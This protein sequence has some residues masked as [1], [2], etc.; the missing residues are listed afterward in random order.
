MVS[1]S[2]QS[3]TGQSPTQAALDEIARALGTRATRDA[4]LGART[5]YRVG[6]RAALLVEAADEAD[7]RA[8]H[9]ALAAAGGT[10]GGTV[11]VLVIGR[12]SNMLVADAGFPGLVIALGGEF[13][14]VEIDRNA[15]KVRAGGA[16]GLQALA[17]ET[18][19]AGL[20]GFEWAVGIPGSIGGA[21]RMNAGGHG[22]QMADVLTWARIFDLREGSSYTR[23]L[24]ELAMGYRTSSVGAGDVVSGAE[25][26]LAVCDPETAIANVRE[27]VR[28]RVDN[29]PGGLNAGSVFTNPPGDSAG[30][31]IDAA[32]LKGLRHGSAVVSDKHANFFQCDSRGSADDVRALI[33]VVRAAVAEREGVELVTELCMVGFPDGDGDGDGSTGGPDSETGAPVDEESTSTGGSRLSGGSQSSSSSRQASSDESSAA[34]EEASPSTTGRESG[35][36]AR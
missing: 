20:T 32:G 22:S 1:P 36:T 10:A 2:G 17:R 5:T 3:P 15:A 29:Q 19:G 4:P 27:V 31:L 9:D 6:G 35:A 13:E 30:R 16:V 23:D 26:A 12:G 28:W 11:P 14:A 24:S 25:L 33:E 34:S 21:V 8:C 18:A 7:L